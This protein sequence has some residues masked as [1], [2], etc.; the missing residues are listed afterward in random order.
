MTLAVVWAE[1]SQ[2]SFAS[3]HWLLYSSYIYI[4][5]TAVIFYACTII[6][7]FSVVFSAVRTVRKFDFSIVIKETCN[8]WQP[9][10]VEKL[11]HFLIETYVVTWYINFPV[12][13]IRSLPTLQI[14]CIF[15]SKGL[16]WRFCEVF[17]YLTGVEYTISRWSLTLKSVL[18]ISG[19]FAYMWS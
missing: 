4:G 17:M 5:L 11:C 6:R 7:L 3:G 12:S 1:E 10:L 14:N 16:H 19:N 15:L 18:I 9:V 2:P 8:K 13:V